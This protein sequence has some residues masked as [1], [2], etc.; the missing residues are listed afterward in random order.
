MRA[1]S[2]LPPVG[3][4][5]VFSCSWPWRPLVKC[6]CGVRGR[7]RT[8]G[9]NERGAGVAPQDSDVTAAADRRARFAPLSS[10]GMASARLPVYATHRADAYTGRRSFTSFLHTRREA[11]ESGDRAPG[12]RAV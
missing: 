12:L 6:R 8:S 5:V 11:H 10:H 2:P 3:T 4:H 7:G 1:R 9:V